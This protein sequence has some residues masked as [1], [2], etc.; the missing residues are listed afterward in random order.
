MCLES[1]CNSWG[2]QLIHELSLRIGYTFQA[3]VR[4]VEDAKLTPEE[5]LIPIPQELLIPEQF[6]KVLHGTTPCL[7][8]KWNS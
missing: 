5:L 4:S 6:L 2:I 8:S 1:E 7:E 3:H